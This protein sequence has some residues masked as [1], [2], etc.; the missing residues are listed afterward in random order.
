MKT[1][2]EAAMKHADVALPYNPTLEPIESNKERDKQIALEKAFLAGVSWAER[3]I[4]VDEE[5]PDFKE[6]KYVLG[7]NKNQ[8]GV[9]Y[10]V[11]YDIRTLKFCYTHW[12]PVEH[13]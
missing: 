3:W 5:L 10:A 11:V 12:R 9:Y 2:K 8:D 13:K 4:P 7:R 1:I 6:H